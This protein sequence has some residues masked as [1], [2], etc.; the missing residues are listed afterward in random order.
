LS[1]F[2]NLNFSDNAITFLKNGENL[3]FAIANNIATRFA[4]Y[5]GAE[6]VLLLN[7]DTI[8]TPAFLKN[9][10]DFSKSNP[11]YVALTPLICLAEPRD[12]IWNCGGRITWFGNRRYFFAGQNISKVPDIKY[13]D[14]TFITGCALYYKPMITGLLSEQF[15]FGEEDFEFSLRLRQKKLKMAC[16]YNSVIHHK[17]GNSINKTAKVSFNAIFLQYVSRLIDHKN[18]YIFPFRWLI[19]VMNSTYG[20]YLT[21]ILYKYGFLKSIKFWFRICLYVIKHD[22]ISKNDFINIMKLSF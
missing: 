10:L 16:V 17:V 1:K 21:F 5:N 19:M 14:I 22:K 6:E 13:S 7:N 9:L 8:V 12:I 18:Y 11:D 2:D 20:F 3:G 15:F 4:L